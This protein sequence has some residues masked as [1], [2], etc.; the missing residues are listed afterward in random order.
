MRRRS[1]VDRGARRDRS[2][3]WRCGPVDHRTILHGRGRFCN[4]RARRCSSTR[5]STAGWRRRRAQAALAERSGFAGVWAA[6]VTRDPMLT[7]AAAAGSTTRR[8]RRLERGAGLHPQPDERGHAG[9]GP[10]RR[11][12]RP[13]RPRPG[14]PGEAPHHPPLLHAVERSR[15]PDAGVRRRPAPHLRGLPGRAPARLPRP[16]LLPH[17][18]A[19]HVQPR[20]DRA[21]PHPDRSRRRRAAADRPGRRGGRRLPAARLH[22]HRLPGQG[23]AAG[24]GRGLAASGRTRADI[25]VFGYL[26]LVAGDTEEE[27]ARAADRIRGQI[28]F[29]A[30][31][32]MYREVLDCIGCAE[33][34]PDL[35]PARQGRVGGPRC[36]AWSTTTCS[37]TSSCGARSRSC[38]RAS[39]RATARYYDRAVP[40]LAL[41]A[42]RPRPPGSSS[43]RPSAP[44][45]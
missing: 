41:D 21:P 9:L 16:P 17:A 2:P 31:S 27:Q 39:G 26:M 1:P 45:A 13:V 12:R 33:L 7:L 22:Q 37:T 3:R 4:Y 20:P 19:R 15:R 23:D 25:W 30:S 38:R 5:S 8:H 29:Y 34:Q 14:H 32:P 36:R 6:E 18:A 10:G 42:R 44:S 11:H 40:Y 24:A 43:S 28:A 35:A